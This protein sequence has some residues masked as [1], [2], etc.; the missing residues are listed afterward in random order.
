MTYITIIL[1][2]F[3]Q[4][5]SFTLVSRTRNR[6]N[7]MYH[8]ICSVFSNGIWFLTM[9]ILVVSDFKWV[10]AIP[11]IFGTVT[12]SLFGAK[13]AMWVEKKIGAKA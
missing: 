6:D 9:G 2:A 13:V 5:I 1:L 7:M 8:A 11:Y 4:N 3:I 10:L 12:G